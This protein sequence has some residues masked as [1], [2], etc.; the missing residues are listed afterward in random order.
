MS[1]G[2]TF[3]EYRNFH[4]SRAI[5]KCWGLT[6][7][8]RTDINNINFL[9]RK[10][11]GRHRPGADHQTVL[12]RNGTPDHLQLAPVTWV[13]TVTYDYKNAAKKA[14][15]QWLNPVVW[16]QGVHDDRSG[17]VQWEIKPSQASR[18]YWP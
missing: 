9:E 10:D 11:R 4:H 7:Q 5:W 18:R 17:G 8:I 13:A 15:D 6:V 1:Y 2:E 14:G 12:D 3:T 16:G